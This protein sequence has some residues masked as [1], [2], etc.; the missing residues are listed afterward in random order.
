MSRY[1]MQTDK[2]SLDETEQSI[3]SE[4]L[5][6]N[7]YVH[8]VENLTTNDIEQSTGLE[9]SIPIGNI[10]FVEA[11]LNKYHNIKKENPIE[12][13]KYLRTDEFLK[14]E[15]KIV[16]AS[17]L[18]MSGKYFIKNIDTLKDFT[19]AGE[20]MFISLDEMLKETASKNDYSK[21]LSPDTNMIISNIFDIESEYRVYVIDGKI[22]VMSNYNGDATV[23][24]DIGLIKKAVGLINLNEKWLKSYTLDIMV[25]NIGTAIIE[26]HNFTSVGLYSTLWGDNLLYAYKQ[27][28]EYLLNDNKKIEV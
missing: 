24:P 26:I 14:R 25:G 4:I 5:R 23:L 17:E 10:V 11:W 21:Y 1:L 2:N 16:K 20:L 22:E 6:K 13:P 28:I 15:Y 8:E 19:Y 12:I 9:K 3:I 18:P 7:R 27:G